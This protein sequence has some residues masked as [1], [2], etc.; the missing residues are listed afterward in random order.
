MTAF[1]ITPATSVF[2]DVFR[3]HAFA[4]DSAGPDSL[5]VDAGAFLVAN[6]LGMGAYL[7][8]TGAWTVSIAGAVVSTYEEGLMVAPGAD[9][10]R[11]AVSAE[12]SVSGKIGIALVSAGTV[13]NAGSIVGTTFYGIQVDKG[14]THTIVN[15]GTIEAPVAIGDSLGVAADSITNSGTLAG[16]V[17]LNGGADSLVNSGTI[18]A[19]VELGDGADVLTN[20]A[21]RAGV[22]VNGSIGGII[23]LGAGNDRFTGGANVERVQDGDGAD[24]V[25]LGAGDDRYLSTGNAGA[26]GLDTVAGGSGTDTW[27]ASASTVAVA[28]NLDTVAHTLA[29]VTTA[30]G[31]L[32][33]QTATGASVAGTSSDRI[34]GFENAAG[35]AAADRLHGSAAENLLEGNGGTDMLFGYGGNDTLSGGASL[36]NL[37]GGAGRDILTGGADADS[38]DFAARSD[39]GATTAT[40][41]VITDFEDVRDVI[42][43]A[44]ID[45]DSTRAGNDA[46]SFIGMHAAFTGHGGELRAVF[47]GSGELIEADTNG[48]GLADFSIALRDTAHSIVLSGADFIL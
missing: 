18:T 40:R 7:E 8:G 29:P 38:F 37:V 39:S 42:N 3:A 27:D 47:S 1:R 4:A 33:A 14:A 2:T 31:T 48:D 19:Y 17:Y 9:G 44:G 12:G 43:L 41:D 34:N 28:V 20:F 21:T 11:I 23:D 22:T 46:F 26:D 5:T 24:N 32:A 16:G 10:S 30:G 36:D 25:A 13:E 35:G 15:S 45:A 6:R